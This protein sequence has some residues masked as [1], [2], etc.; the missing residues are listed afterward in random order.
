MAE[1]TDAVMHLVAT[2]IAEGLATV[3]GQAIAAVPPSRDQLAA[4]AMQALL[5]KSGYEPACPRLAPAA[6]RVA[7]AMLAERAKVKP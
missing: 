3:L 5:S 1:L 2:G 4:M 7:D 6:Y